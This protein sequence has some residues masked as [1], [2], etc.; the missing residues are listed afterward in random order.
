MNVSWIEYKA[1]CRVDWCIFYLRN[2]FIIIWE[3]VSQPITNVSTL[4]I[5]SCKLC[6]IM[7]MV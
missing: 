7:S 4:V 5:T 3:A 6:K 1:K 2:S